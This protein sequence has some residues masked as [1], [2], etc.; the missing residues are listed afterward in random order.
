MTT[1]LF[2]V[3]VIFTHMKKRKRDIKRN[4]M[5]QLTVRRTKNDVFVT[6]PARNND[7]SVYCM[8]S[9]FLSLSLLLTYLSS[10]RC[11]VTSY[12][13]SHTRITFL[14]LCLSLLFIILKILNFFFVFFSSILALNLLDKTKDNNGSLN[15]FNWY[16]QS[17]T[18]E[19]IYQ[20]GQSN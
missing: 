7:E 8:L 13:H 1:I 12:I 5:M 18:G 2:V 19:R 14:H 11:E 4:L 20:E 17:V 16:H 3:V 10:N 15:I 6:T 9:L